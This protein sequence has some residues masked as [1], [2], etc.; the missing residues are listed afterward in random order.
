VKIPCGPDIKKLDDEAAVFLDNKA[1]KVLSSNSDILR[2][3]S[4]RAHQSD[5]KVWKWNSNN[6][7]SHEFT[8]KKNVKGI[9]GGTPLDLKVQRVMT[10]MGQDNREYEEVFHEWAGVGKSALGKFGTR[11]KGRVQELVGKI[12]RGEFEER[13][14]WGMSNGWRD[15]LDDPLV[16]KAIQV[17]KRIIDRGTKRLREVGI[18]DKGITGPQFADT[19][20][21]RRYNKVAIK[22]GVLNDEGQT[23]AEKMTE[24]FRDNHPEMLESEI[25]KKVDESIARI[26]H[27]DD[28]HLELDSLTNHFMS[29]G[30]SKSFLKERVIPI[31]DSDLHPWLSKDVQG[32]ASNFGMQAEALAAMKEQF[33][34][35][36][37]EL[38]R[39]IEKVSDITKMLREEFEDKLAALKEKLGKK[40]HIGP[41]APELD[42]EVAKLTQSFKNAEDEIIAQWRLA[43]GQYGDADS[44][45]FRALR[46]YNAMTMLGGVALASIPDI[47]MLIFKNG[48]GRV[49]RELF[50]S[51]GSTWKEAKLSRKQMQQLAGVIDMHMDEVVR[52]Q[53]DPTF[54]AGGLPDNTWQR[55]LN[56]LSSLFTSATGINVINRNVA[57]I[58][59]DIQAT[60]ITEAFINLKGGKALSKDLSSELARVGIGKEQYKI[61]ERNLK[62]VK[63]KNGEVF[64]NIDLWD[65]E[66]QELMGDAVLRNQTVLRPTAGDLPRW[67]MGNNFGKI[68]FQFKSFLSTAHNR[69]LIAGAQRA[70]MKGPAGSLGSKEVQGMFA[71]VGMGAMSYMIRE[72]LAGRG[73]DL[74]LSLDNLI[75]EGILRSGVGGLLA[76]PLAL[77]LPGERNGRYAALGAMGMFG[78]PS[79]AQ[80]ARAVEVLNGALDGELSEGELRKAARLAP[81]NNLYYIQGLFNAL[82]D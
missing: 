18:L 15:R 25:K 35:M 3:S 27:M 72:E 59:A 19:W 69:I 49:G 26:M 63:T 2:G 9:A 21:A 22:S 50:R 73:D 23:F 10:M 55:K 57:T 12:D 8:L 81:Y 33:E 65:S 16:N 64:H 40:A 61:I 39:P 29:H 78:G 34:S 62:H 36:S 20:F 76:D 11:T 5:W 13:V 66:A 56:Q 60:V 48:M 75:T 1:F 58:G 53:T 32:T 71:L 17:Q 4:L 80:G 45:H 47:A 54:R 79:L 82:G 43:T 74:D 44:P 28:E 41:N 68:I 7:L 30:E 31:D 67:A 37:R 24:S 42:K 51:M 14:R 77:V 52:Y 46:K 70:A 38:V 6:T